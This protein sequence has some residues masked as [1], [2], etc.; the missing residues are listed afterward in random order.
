MTKLMS[1]RTRD[2]EGSMML[3]FFVLLVV[4]GLTVVS[5]ATA[6][7][8]QK[9]T[10][11]TQS[12]TQAL[13]AADKNIERAVLMLNTNQSTALPAAPGGTEL[14]STTGCPKS[15]S[16]T[17]WYATKVAANA[18]KVWSRNTVNGVTRCVHATI[19]QPS[20][21]NLAA[22]ADASVQFRGANLANSYNHL[23]AANGTGNGDVGSNDFV[24][25]NG[26]ATA[27]G[28]QLYDWANDPNSARCSGAICGGT[29]TST[30]D[31]AL[32]IS[33]NASQVFIRDALAA[34]GTTLPAYVSSQSSNTLPAGVQCYSSMNFDSTTT[35]QGTTGT[36]CDPTSAGYNP[37]IVYVLGNI[38]V[39]NHLN[40]NFTS[41]TPN[42]C[43]LQ[44]YM[45][46]SSVAIGNHSNVAAAIYAP[47]AD[48][49]GNPSNAQADVYGS[50]ICKSIG[51]QGGWTFH[52]DDALS[53]MGN[54]QW[55]VYHFGE[56]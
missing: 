7:A 54:G 18:Y 39:G 32:D 27:D 14:D 55:D 29:T 11:H 17:T 4:G 5:L 45:L 37:T 47:N 30:V 34:C 2:D 46:G 1:R 19:S 13:P 33:S 20:R 36:S 50:A 25:F 35:V 15:T 42:A 38:S 41:S 43:N 12:F 53:S 21:F 48:C 3:F 23:T 56:N 31:G 16:T 40:V 6:V 44:I 28:V 51:N 49:S 8:T 24:T 26:N 9:S 52:Y 10:R 22:F